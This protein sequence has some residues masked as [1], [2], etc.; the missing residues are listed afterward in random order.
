MAAAA[1]VAAAV[2]SAA[3]TTVT[4]GPTSG[5]WGRGHHPRAGR[6]RAVHVVGLHRVQRGSNVDEHSAV[7]PGMPEDANAVFKR[8]YT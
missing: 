1:A 8:R 2:T 3:V 5:K 4:A 7:R 6:T